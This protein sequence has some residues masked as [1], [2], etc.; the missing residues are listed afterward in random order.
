VALA[1]DAAAGVETIAGIVSPTA[2]STATSPTAA[3]KPLPAKLPDGCGADSPIDG[4]NLRPE[5][6]CGT[7]GADRIYAGS[8]DVVKGGA[9]KDTIFAKNGGP[10][11]VYGGPG[12]DIAYVDSQWDRAADVKERYTSAIARPMAPAGRVL[13]TPDGFPYELMT[14]E[15]DDDDD[16]KGGRHIL[17]LDPPNHKPQ[18][19]AFNANRGVVD[20]QNVAWTTLIYKQDQAGA[21]N[22]IYQT[23]WLW[24]RTY[25][26]VDF[27]L[28]SHPANT[29]R[30][31]KEGED[32]TEADQE[33]FQITEPGNYTVRF[34]Y[35]WLPE[36]A[37]P[38]TNL[39]AMPEKNL[40]TDAR[41]TVGKYAYDD[42]SGHPYCIIPSP[43]T[44]GGGN[45]VTAVW[46]GGTGTQWWSTGLSWADF[47][48]QDGAYFN[49]G[50][51]L[52]DL[53]VERGEYT[54]VWQPGSGAQ[55]V[56]TGLTW[57]S[58]KA[59]DQEY[60]NQGLRLVDIEIDGGLYSAVWRPGTGAQ[61]VS[62]GLSLDD[63]K[64]KNQGYFDQ[65][66]R[67]V[68]IEIDHGTYTGV[69]RPG[70]GAQSWWT[71]MSAGTL[72]AKDAAYQAQGLRISVLKVQ[73]G[74]YTAVWQP[75]TGS[76]LIELGTSVERFLA[77]DKDNFRKGFRLKALEV[78]TG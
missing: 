77:E 10:N 76:Q 42:G 51:R 50:L 14:V 12:D 39:A 32:D 43:S 69:W 5:I 9:G 64:T 75:G 70:S 3:G 25:D 17:L 27:T 46:R 54:G 59:K 37:P 67:L 21:W 35:S 68:D 15:C 73:D 29:W 16:G 24:D 7:S 22:L 26:L 71:G 57:E 47:K 20:W 62:T 52:V 61:W 19:A 74:A 48:K 6:V 31:F 1:G 36:A 60:L 28:K 8:G 53:E 58:F 72:A 65:G 33:P 41:K 40:F 38:G 11:D 56:W 2:R 45:L 49:Q 78:E 18:M 13:T 23:D 44:S 55:W 30:S 66:L 34:K 63:F 4:R